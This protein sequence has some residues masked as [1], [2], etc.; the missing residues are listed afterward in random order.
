M[1]PA[2]LYLDFTA[3]LR[4]SFLP[5]SLSSPRS[6]TTLLAHR[7]EN[8]KSE[9]ESISA[10][11]HLITLLPPPSRFLLLYLLDLLSVFVRS[12]S[13]NLMSASN[14]AVVFQPGLVSTRREGTGDAALLGFPGFVG[15]KVPVGGSAAAAAGA[16]A[17]EGAGEHGKGKEVLEFLIE[18]QSHFM[19]GLAPPSPSATKA[20][21]MREAEDSGYGPSGS[22]PSSAGGGGG[23][24]PMG[25]GTTELNRRGSE[26]SVERRRLRKSHDGGNGKV[27]RSRTLPG[28]RHGETTDCEFFASPFVRR[29]RFC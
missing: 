8:S 7:S 10:Y 21:R 26:K 20:M 27:K 11:Q 2:N 1:I 24:T 14:L 15:G 12:S 18:Q 25:G 16:R 3:V 19:M 22:S 29:F 6:L 4:S 13:A 17:V 28:G 23:V 5:L 9:A